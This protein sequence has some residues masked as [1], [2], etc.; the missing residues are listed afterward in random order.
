[1]SGASLV[2]GWSIDFVAIF[3]DHEHFNTHRGLIVAGTSL[4][5]NK[6][7]FIYVYEL[8]MYIQRVII[9]SKVT[10]SFSSIL[11]IGTDLKK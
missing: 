4:I 11:L 1:M 3:N 5:E 7:Q 6:L 2:P 8:Y 10:S 9:K